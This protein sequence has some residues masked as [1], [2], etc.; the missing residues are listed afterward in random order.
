MAFIFPWGDF[1]YR[2]IPFDLKNAR[3]AFQR[4]MKF[5]FPDL[6]HIVES[7]LDILTAHSCKRVNHST[8]L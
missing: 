4:A 1:A 3:A 7:Y 8:Y 2:K 6:K 5:Y